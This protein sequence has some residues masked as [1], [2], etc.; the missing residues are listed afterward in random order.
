M[1]SVPVLAKTVWKF[2]GVEVK[3]NTK[4]SH[5]VRT[6]NSSFETAEGFIYFGT[7]LTN[8][9]SIQEETEHIKVRKCLP[10]CG[11]K[12]LSSSVLSRNVKI[13][14]YR[15]IILPA[16]LYGRETWSLNLREE[17]RLRVF[18]NMVLRKIFGAKRDEIT[19][20]WRKLHNEE[21]NDLYFSSSIVR[22]IKSGRNRW[23]GHV[24]RIG[25]IVHT[26]F[27]LGKLEGRKPLVRPRRR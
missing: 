2:G 19:G 27:W 4:R 13:K 6:D 17:L 23:A 24:T 9:N 1:L 26:E 14:I 11:V 18:E 5:I 8:Q 20:E 25:R 15:N 12:S 10:S 16:V 21:L 3:L 7:N 22:V